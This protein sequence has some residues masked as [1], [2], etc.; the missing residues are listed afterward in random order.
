MTCAAAVWIRDTYRRTGGRRK[1]SMHYNRR[2]CKREAI[3]GASRT[4]VGRSEDLCWQHADIEIRVGTH[5]PRHE[6]AAPR[7]I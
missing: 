3:G 6:S 5:Q 4:F 1:F 7:R 2:R